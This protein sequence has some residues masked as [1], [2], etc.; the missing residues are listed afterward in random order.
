MLWSLGANKCQPRTKFDKLIW[1]I[2]YEDTKQID[3]MT[4]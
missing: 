1:F 2:F 3:Q 4:D